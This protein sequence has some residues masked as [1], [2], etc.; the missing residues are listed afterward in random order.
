MNERRWRNIRIDYNDGY[1]I[2]IHRDELEK[3]SEIANV[4]DA[5]S[6][7]KK[8]AERFQHLIGEKD[9]P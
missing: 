6:H 5:L 2:N 3:L 9:S 4:I 7:A 8:F 1:A